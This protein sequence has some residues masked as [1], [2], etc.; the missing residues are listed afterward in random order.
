MTWKPH[1][2]FSQPQPLS[3][4]N[5]FLFDTSLCEALAREGVE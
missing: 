2:V 4:S 3:N 1:T 5:L